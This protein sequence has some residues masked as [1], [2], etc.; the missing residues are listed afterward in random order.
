MAVRKNLTFSP[1]LLQ[2]MEALK[3]R[4]KYRTLSEYVQGLV[5]YDAQT[6]RDHT[7]SAEWASLD[8]EEQSFLDAAFLALVESGQGIKGTVLEDHI[9][10]FVQSSFAAQKPE[11]TIKEVAMAIGRAIGDDAQR[12]GAVEHKTSESSTIGFSPDLLEV[13]EVLRKRRKYR[14]LSEYIQGLARYDAQTQRDHTFSADWAALSPKERDMLDANL[15]KQVLAGEGK[16]GSWLE[17]RI[18]DIILEV[19]RPEEL[20]AKKAT[21]KKNAA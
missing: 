1:S 10:H 11:P 15:L 6:Q 14:K 21:E 18:Y 19:Y 7:L 5:R 17:A 16:R 4:H 13:A 3:H 9:R 8:H 2:A 20:K 12:K